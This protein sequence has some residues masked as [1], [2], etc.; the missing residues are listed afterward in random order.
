M[1]RSKLRLG[2]PIEKSGNHHGL[3]LR[4]HPA[5]LACCNLIPAGV[6]IRLSRRKKTMNT[7]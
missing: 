5:I 6:A 7:L 1:K 3:F 4:L 2:K